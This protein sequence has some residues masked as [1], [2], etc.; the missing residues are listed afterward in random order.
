M[1]NLEQEIQHMMASD[2][3]EWN[4]SGQYGGKITDDNFVYDNWTTYFRTT[5]FLSVSVPLHAIDKS[6]L[7]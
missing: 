1:L 4:H 5:L 7:V 2:D 6:A 3:K